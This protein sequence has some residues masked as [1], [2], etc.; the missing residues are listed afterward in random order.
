M[1]ETEP[2]IFLIGETRKN[3]TEIWKYFEHIGLD[4]WTTNAPSDSEYMVEF[5]GRM[6]YGAWKPG[7]NPNITRVRKGNN[8]YINNILKSGHGSVL[9]HSSVNWV[10]ADVSRVFT[11]EL[12]RHRVGTAISQQ[13]QRYFRAK[14]LKFWVPSD[15]EVI[16]TDFGTI[17]IEEVALAK[18]LLI[19]TVSMIEGQMQKLTEIFKLDSKDID[20]DLK[21]RLTTIVRRI[22]PEGASTDIGWTC[23]MRTLRHLL[24]MR[25][26]VH[27]EEEI[28]NVFEKIGKR[29]QHK[30][31]NLFSDFKTEM[32]R[33]YLEFTTENRKV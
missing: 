7:F 16:S 3:D 2:S 9:E 12:V 17:T 21:K 26:S 27:A 20:F 33:G 4:S 30:Y 10:I 23:N 8:V 18:E 25:T 29:V 6:C 19:E 11:H 31:P 1:I 14:E 28:R 32:I 13:S 22:A 15:M 24:E 5:Y